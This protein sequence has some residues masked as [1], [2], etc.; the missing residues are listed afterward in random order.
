MTAANFDLLSE[1]TQAALLDAQW[2]HVRSPLMLPVVR[3]K[4]EAG[5]G[6]ALLRWL[7]LDPT[8]A[9]AF[10]LQ[11]VVRPTPRFSPTYLSPDRSLP[12]EQQRQIAANFVTLKSPDELM[13]SATLLHRYTG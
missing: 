5:D 13:R 12:A 7:E 10:M 3:R 8:P 1:N 2:D 6:H 11:E 9:T 4:A